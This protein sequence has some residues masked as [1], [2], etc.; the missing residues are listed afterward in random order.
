MKQGRLGYNHENGRY[1]LLSSDLWVN[2]GFH[3]GEVME[4]LVDDIWVETRIEMKFGG[5][6]YIV[7]TPY[8]GNLENVIARIN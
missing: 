3:C 7:G 6:W 5:E 2:D 1:G 4:V 8:S